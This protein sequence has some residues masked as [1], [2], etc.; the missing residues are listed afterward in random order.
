M[1]NNILFWR[2]FSRRSAL[3]FFI[4][5]LLF[6]T[7][8]LRIT[9]IA[10]S[11]Y[12]LIQEQQN[13]LKLKIKNLRG[14]I[15]DCNYIPLTNNQKKIIA[16]ITP[17]PRAVTALSS[18]LKGEELENALNRLRNG[19][20][21]LCEV[22]EF[23]ECDGIVCAEIYDNS[24]ENTVAIHTV[25][26]TDNENNGVSGLEKAYNDILKSDLS[27][28]IH[29]EC[30]GKGEILEGADPKVYNDTSVIAGGIVSTL[31]INIQIIAEELSNAIETGAIVIADAKNGKIRASVSRPDF[32]IDNISESLN[33]KDSPMLNRAISSYNVGSVFKPCVAIAGIENKKSGFCYNCTGSCEIIDRHFKCHNLNGHG[34]LDL[35]KGLAYS[36]NTY[37]YNFAFSIGAKEILKTASALQFG[38][39]LQLCDEI[40]TAEGNLPESST[41]NNIAQLA[42]FSI[43][44]GELLLTPTSILTLYCSIANN[45]K[46]YIPS[47]V[48]GVLKDGKL[49]PYDIGKPTKVMSENAAEILKNQLVS[50]ITEGTGEDAKPQKI[51][52]A[53]KT[54]TAQT[55][56]F[57]NG[58]EINE[59]WFCG[60]F[61][62]ENPQ[63]VV[64]VFSENTKRQSKTCSKI[65]AE[66]AD[67]ITALKN[68]SSSY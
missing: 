39:S 35:T 37:F 14:T 65:F 62:V 5:L 32:N 10:T 49:T 33:S 11:D 8:I 34:Y 23:I 68:L 60:F 58:V 55:G 56:K 30:N 67:R 4:I 36:C 19:K 22:P 9:A 28:Y 25:G 52:A 26:Y 27:A 43:G 59:G 24:P 29:Y 42:N 20:P 53:G 47:L 6:F 61:P 21:I 57:V 64:I 45:G 16:A 41:L 46:Y 51:T 63:Y 44:Q 18:V 38:K 48:E 3:C 31:D 50:V 15:Y 17:T 12:Y 54:A 13:S 7:C 66:I 2:I 40:K 1:S